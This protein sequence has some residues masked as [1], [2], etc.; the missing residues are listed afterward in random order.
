M[1]DR[2]KAVISDMDGV[3]VNS[4]HNFYRAYKIILDREGV[5]NFTE[6]YYR[7]YF[8]AR[9]DYTK[10]A[11]ERDFNV[12]L[13]DTEAFKREKDSN[14]LK[15]AMKHTVP[16]DTTVEAVKKL[17]RVYKI[18]VASSSDEKIVEHS[19]QVI[20]LDS[21][22]DVKVPGNHVDRSKPNPDIFLKACEELKVKTSDCVV[23]EDS[24]PGMNAAYNA[25]IPCIC[26]LADDVDGSRYD[27]ALKS[28]RISKLTSDDLI[29]NIR[30]ILS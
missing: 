26:L 7:Q 13:G 28:F 27:K 24:V 21:F 12:N 19:L 1:D 4:F 2:K 11:I 17:S 25:G 10:E 14:Y 16:F 22:V 5:D 18:A 15:N 9:G 30:Q 8:G 23:I 6:A 3:L 20:G 29:E